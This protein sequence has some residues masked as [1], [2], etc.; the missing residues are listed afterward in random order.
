[1]VA[2]ENAKLYE[3]IKR[4]NFMKDE[5]IGMASHELKTPV[6][7]IKGYLQIIERNMPEGKS[8][9]FIS[10]ASL[11]V[12]KLTALISDLLDVSKIEAGKLPFS[13]TVFN[14]CVL[15]NDIKD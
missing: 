11:Q 5:F 2:I 10:K 4:L 7:S 3:E 14:L 9:T 1:M 8:K 12:T 6:T 13:Y 15:L